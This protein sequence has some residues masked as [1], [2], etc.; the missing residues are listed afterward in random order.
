MSANELIVI[1]TLQHCAI[2]YCSTDAFSTFVVLCRRTVLHIA[3]STDNIQLA[4]FLVNNGAQVNVR[5]KVC[6]LLHL[7]HVPLLSLLFL[8]LL[9]ALLVDFDII[10]TTTI[11]IR[12]HHWFWLFSEYSTP[13]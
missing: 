7:L 12:L 1:T 6:L 3:V 4:E 2:M 10:I 11:V 8:L 13:T 5:D 9:L